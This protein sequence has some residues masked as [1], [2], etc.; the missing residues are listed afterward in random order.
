METKIIKLKIKRDSSIGENALKIKTKF[1]ESC[2]LLDASIFEPLIE[3]D[4]YFQDLDKYRFL[5]LLKDEF[6]LLRAKGFVRTTVIVGNCMGCQCGDRV[7][8][9][10]TNNVYPAFAYIIKE[11]NNQI[12]DIFMCNWSS[13]MQ[14]V[15][16]KVLENYDFWK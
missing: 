13:G 7:Y 10:Y 15:D 11:E 8:Q 9:F 14:I 5:Q 1:I 2:E 3:E 12:V 16:L 4:Q 6:N